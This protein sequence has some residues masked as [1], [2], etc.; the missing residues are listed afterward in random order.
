MAEIYDPNW[1]AQLAIAIK[2]VI[3]T[4]LGGTTIFRHRE[5]RIVEGLTTATS[6]LFTAAVAITVALSQQLLAVTL[7]LLSLVLLRL[8]RRFEPRERNQT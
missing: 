1:Q 6:L 2:V 7:T 3:A 5:G 8:L 4:V